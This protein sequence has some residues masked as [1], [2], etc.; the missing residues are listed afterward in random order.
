MIADP[1]WEE[2]KALLPGTICSRC[3]AT[4]ENMSEKCPA[5]ETEECPGVLAV[6]AALHRPD[7]A[8]KLT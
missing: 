7:M 6:M 8:K 3:G 2:L 5:P 4:L 1:K